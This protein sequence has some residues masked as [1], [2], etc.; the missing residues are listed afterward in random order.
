MGK[1]PGGEPEWGFNR[2]NIC[3]SYKVS[4]NIETLSCHSDS[5][6]LWARLDPISPLYLKCILLT[7]YNE[8]VIC[9][10]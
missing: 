9:E 10:N 1:A 7:K 5:V 3:S 4:S 8:F 2:C 6:P